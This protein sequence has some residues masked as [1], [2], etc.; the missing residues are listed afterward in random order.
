[1]GHGKEDIRVGVSQALEFSAKL[2]VLGKDAMLLLFDDEGHGLSKL[3][4]LVR[5]YEASGL[6]LQR[7][8]GQDQR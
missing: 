3:E 7:N 6:I 4:N 8:L 1:M 5:F 2:K